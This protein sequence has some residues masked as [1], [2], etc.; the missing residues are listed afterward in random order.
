MCVVLADLSNDAW[1][2]F[3]GEIPKRA[4]R[5]D[6][7]AFDGWMARLVSDGFSAMRVRIDTDMLR[8][9]PIGEDEDIEDFAGS[10]QRALGDRQPELESFLG[11]TMTWLARGDGAHLP[12]GPTLELLLQKFAGFPPSARSS[13]MGLDMLDA[14][15]LRGSGWEPLL[16]DF[17]AEF[18]KWASWPDPPRLDA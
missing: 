2:R 17:E 5:R 4:L 18:G 10:V 3:R 15:V 9:D 11:W 1:I 12:V 7:E 6:G 16:P 13:V 14:Q 8:F